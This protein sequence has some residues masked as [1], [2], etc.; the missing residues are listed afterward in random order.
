M[1][2][3]IEQIRLYNNLY[4]LGKPII[5]DFEYDRLIEK[6]NFKEISE[7][8]SMRAIYNFDD[9]ILEWNKL[10]NNEK[11]IEPKLDGMTL[12]LEYKF[13]KLINAY[14]KGNFD[15]NRNVLKNISSIVPNILKEPLT[16]L[17]RGELIISKTN[18]KLIHKNF[19]SIRS[20]TCGA[21]LGKNPNIVSQRRVCFIA[22]SFIH[23][24]ANNCLEDKEYFKDIFNIIPTLSIMTKF[25]LEEIKNNMN[26]L[27]KT[28]DFECD[29]IVIKLNNYIDQKKLGATSTDDRWL[30]AMKYIKPT[31]TTKVIDIKYSVSKHGRNIPVLIVEPIKFQNTNISHRL[32]NKVAGLNISLLE[33]LS[34]NIGSK[35]AVELRS[36]AIPVLNQV[37]ESVPYK[38]IT[39]CIS[40]NSQLINIDHCININCAEM[41]SFKLLQIFKI[42]KIKQIGIIAVNKFIKHNIQNVASILLLNKDELEIILNSKK[43]ATTIFNQLQFKLKNI[44][45][46]EILTSFSIPGIGMTTL[47]K[48]QQYNK[49][50]NIKELKLTNFENLKFLGPKTAETLYNFIIKNNIE[51]SYFDDILF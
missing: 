11:L 42:L 36:I 3:I 16:I 2:N 9:L 47:K 43:Q 50:L 48:I 15:Q 23:S 46:L 51:L 12:L 10:G 41:K 45:A 29:G 13:G 39:N 32:I 21:V 25:S 49:F 34:I 5:S 20:A 28:Y 27:L 26:N 17:V 14:T 8:K 4:R 6:Y 19:S 24:S 33:S 30:I 37:L 7:I 38:K 31:L 22:F 40:C 1:D 35:I 18:Y 44:T